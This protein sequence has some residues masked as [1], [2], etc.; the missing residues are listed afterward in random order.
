MVF[1]DAVRAP[2]E[3]TA[4]HLRAASDALVAFRVDPAAGLD[5]AEAERRLQ[6]DGPNELRTS[7][8][9]P[10]WR[11]ILAQFQ[12]PL[13][14]LLL[15]AIAISLGAWA[16]EGATGAPIDAV[17][18]A[19]VV[20]LNALL[21]LVQENKAENAVAALKSMTAATSTVWRDGELKTVPAAELVLGDI[22]VLGEGDA[23]GLM[24]G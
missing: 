20:L 8:R 15:V 5:S 1:F 17:V 6:T 22:L 21:G 24:P 23:V 4:W 9:V 16:V 14:Y 2:V 10:R 11:K 3:P 19:A 7:A 18:I 13:I 12:D